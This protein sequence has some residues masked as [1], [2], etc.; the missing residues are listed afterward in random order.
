MSVF[1]SSKLL[2]L[3]S[4][5]LIVVVLN[6]SIDPPDL[7]K[8]LDNDIALEEDTSINEMESISEV[9][10]EQ[11]LDLDN[12]IPETDDEE[13][14][15]YLKKVEIFQSNY[16]LVCPSMPIISIVSQEK[17]CSFG[18]LFIKQASLKTLS[19]PPKA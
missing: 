15:T 16:V 11:V 5:A 18:S 14:E 13:T 17:T 8:N 12:A 19:P 10:L 3:I 2:R 4:L 6:V 1:R 7:L 9:V